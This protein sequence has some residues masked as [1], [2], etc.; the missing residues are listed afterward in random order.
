[1]SFYVEI[2]NPIS[3]LRKTIMKRRR[4]KTKANKAVNLLIKQHIRNREI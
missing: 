4:L 2:M 3:L 1:M